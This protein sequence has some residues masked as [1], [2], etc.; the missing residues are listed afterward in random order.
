[1]KYPDENCL[2][3]NLE[4]HIFVKKSNMHN[5]RLKVNDTIYDK[6]MWLLSKFS[7]DE[8]EIIPEASDFSKNQKYLN[9]ELNDILKGNANFIEIDETEQRLENIIARHEDRI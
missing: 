6:L 8:I 2:P 1:M 3:V 9:D 7:K 4:F 5:V